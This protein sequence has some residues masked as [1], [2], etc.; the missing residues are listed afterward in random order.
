MAGRRRNLDQPDEVIRSDRME[1]KVVRLGDLTVGKAIQQPGW[2]W[3]SDL[4]PTVGGEWCQAR[5]VGMVLRGRMHTDFADGSTRY[6]A[7]LDI[8]GSPSVRRLRRALPL[9]VIVPS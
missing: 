6:D 1:T 8:G 5:H 4:Q 7:V 9:S 2:R 3:S